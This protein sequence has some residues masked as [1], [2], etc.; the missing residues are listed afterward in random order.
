MHELI[1]KSP[2]LPGVAD[3]D[4]FFDFIEHHAG[5]DPARLRLKY[6][7]R[8]L[9]FDLDFALTQIEVRRRNRSKLGSLL[10]HPHFVVPSRLAAEQATLPA[11]AAWHASLTS[12]S[13]SVLDMTCGLGID[14]MAMASAG[15]EVI[16]FDID[17]V[18]AEC[19]AWNAHILNINT[20]KAIEG[21]SLDWLYSQGSDSEFDTV[22]IDPARRNGT[23]RLYALSDCEPDVTPHVP[24]LLR[25]APRLLV[26]CSPML[27]VASVASTLPN[28]KNLSVVSARGE[29][30][31]L[32][33]ECERGYTGNPF[34]ST[35]IINDTT[36][37]IFSITL[38][39]GSRLSVSFAT[40][41]DLTRA[42][43]IYEPD[44]ALMKIAAWPELQRIYSSLIKADVNTHLFVSPD[45]YP[46]F[47]G[48][49][50]E[51]DDSGSL[52]D[53]MRKYKGSAASAVCRNAPLD[54]AEL[55]KRLRLKDD[56]RTFIYCCRAAGET[57]L[58]HARRLSR[59]V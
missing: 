25:H 24:E 42:R 54:A 14:A 59:D 53:F 17:S 23:R 38:D 58:W 41:H 22:F 16:A 12:G 28:L 19:A 36:E 8:S 51:V 56:D 55:K 4:A 47:P 52:R 13:R 33:A 2:K 3:K 50:C 20:L 31:E 43:F 7:G 45:H 18:K 27:D 48:R 57:L 26:K 34:I 49:V 15:A 35:V 6:A 46:S 1:G 11:I 9:P 29:C 21:N 44:A 39:S 40:P 37:E 32:L 5:E 30:K 10:S